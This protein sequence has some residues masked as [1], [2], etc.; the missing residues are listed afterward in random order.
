MDSGYRLPSKETIRKEDLEKLLRVE[1][2]NKLKCCFKLTRFH[3]DCTGSARQRVDLAAQV[4]SRS[5]A[6]LLEQTRSDKP[7]SVELIRLFNDFFDVMNSRTKVDDKGNVLKGGYGTALERQEQI[8]DDMASMIVKLR[9][10]GAKDSAALL[11]FQNGIALACAGM[12]SF[13]SYMKENYPVSYVLT[14]RLNQD[15]IENLF[16]R[17]RGIGGTHDHPNCT[18][19]LDRLRLL[20]VGQDSAIVV[21]RSAVRM[22]QDNEV[23]EWSSSA[24]VTGEI[25]RQI[26]S[27]EENDD[28]DIRRRDADADDVIE[29]DVERMEPPPDIAEAQD[30]LLRDPDYEAL[31][32]HLDPEAVN[33]ESED[34]E[35]L[36]SD[37]CDDDNDDMDVQLTPPPPPA[38]VA[39]GNGKRQFDAVDQALKFVAGWLARCFKDDD[40]CEWL[41]LGPTDH[42]PPEFL[43]EFPWLKAISRGGLSVPNPIFVDYLREME[44]D[45]D[46][47][48]DKPEGID[49]EK[50][51]FNRMA[52]V[53]YDKYPG[54]QRK[55]ILKYVRFR[56]FVLI[57]WLN[58]Q[59][60]LEKAKSK[61]GKDRPGGRRA[62]RKT[63]HV[64]T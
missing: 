42:L 61:K 17:L 44:T 60:T 56:T 38:A 15:F 29:Y 37:S 4:W 12:K 8:L 9:K 58:Y 47:F 35:D 33:D 3:L 22:E 41:W 62:A 31:L 16:S 49:L 21:E 10:V 32:V 45:F 27:P 28:E 64:T 18:E 54:V 48:H 50:D 20:M 23:V 34:D 52:K 51:V 43:E 14:S 36:G 11:P 6:A 63:R 25:G 46:A 53:L 2:H 19:A 5:T 1:E 24:Q 40:D 13:Y 7:G 59:L 30:E 57:K 55:V 26:M 39:E